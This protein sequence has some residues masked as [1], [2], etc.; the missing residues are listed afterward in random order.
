[1][2]NKMPL[3]KLLQSWVFL[4]IYPSIHLFFSEVLHDVSDQQSGTAQSLAKILIPQ[5]L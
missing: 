4:F 5:K 2:Q 1:M 3:Q